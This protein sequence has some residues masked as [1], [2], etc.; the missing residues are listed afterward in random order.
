MSLTATFHLLASIIAGK[1]P[2]LAA[3]LVDGDGV[4]SL[5]RLWRPA[6]LP[7]AVN[8]P[9]RSAIQRLTGE[10]DVFHIDRTLSPAVHDTHRQIYSQIGASVRL[11]GHADL[12]T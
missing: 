1:L 9:P 3:V 12:R 8:Q 5:S 6:R 4:S 11:A 2:G 7:T 10:V